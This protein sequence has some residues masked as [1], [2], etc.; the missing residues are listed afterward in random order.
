MP[1]KQE[2]ITA[3]SPVTPT[4]THTDEHTGVIAV[5]RNVFVITVSVK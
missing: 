1:V 5:W 3:S 2:K 4:K